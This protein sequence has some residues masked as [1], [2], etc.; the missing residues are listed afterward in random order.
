M[1]YFLEKSAC[2]SVRAKEIIKK[3]LNTNVLYLKNGK[4]YTEISPVSISHSGDFVLV[5][6]SENEIGVD[7]EI[8]K[9]FDKRLISRYFTPAEQK[10][11]KTDDDFFAIWTVK[12]AYLKMTGE[13]LKG[14]TKL[15]VVA[16][17]KIYLK[18][19][20]ILSF[21]EKGCMVAIVYK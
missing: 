12:E 19:C 10:F 20:N 4:P 3:Q 2:P 1:K 17:N 5:G 21:V 11:I 7:I 15:N 9:P 8:I 18:G 14:I 6:I 16:N 13:G